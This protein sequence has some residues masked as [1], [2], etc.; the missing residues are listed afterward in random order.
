M[1]GETASRFFSL[2][3]DFIFIVGCSKDNNNPVEGAP[4]NTDI[5]QDPTNAAPQPTI[6]KSP[7]RLRLQPKSLETQ[8]GFRTGFFYS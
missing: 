8:T 7:L 5:P 6:N 4:I 3:V 1:K 2:P